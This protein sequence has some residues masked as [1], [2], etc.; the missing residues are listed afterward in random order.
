MRTQLGL[1]LQYLHDHQQDFFHELKEFVAFASVSAEPGHYPDVHNAAEWVA[2]KLLDLGMRNVALFATARHPIVYGEYLGAGKEAPTVLVYGHYDVE[3]PD[4]V[5]QW[6]SPPFK[7]RVR[8]DHVYGRGVADMKGQL[9]LCMAALEAIARTGTLPVNL[10]F[11]L[12][13][14][15]RSVPPA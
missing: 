14:R 11:S 12:R 9:I 8:G 1:A 5:D 10:K 13:A 15:K 7:A 6:K 2:G 4:P 3:P